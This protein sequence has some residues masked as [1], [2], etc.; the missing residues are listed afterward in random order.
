M[1][2]QIVESRD[3]AELRWDGASEFIREETPEKATESMEHI[4]IASQ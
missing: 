1:R 4:S 2:V 3:F